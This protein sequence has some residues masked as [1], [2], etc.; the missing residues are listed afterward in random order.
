MYMYIVITK[1]LS[2]NVF[3]MQAQLLLIFKNECVMI[4]NQGQ[5]VKFAEVDGYYSQM[6]LSWTQSGAKK[7]LIKGN[8]RVQY[9]N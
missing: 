2:S 1:F 9:I 5:K 3:L 6:L 7:N 4:L 8:P